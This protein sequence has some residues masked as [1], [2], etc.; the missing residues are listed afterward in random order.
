MS[1]KPSR[2]PW[3]PVIPDLATTGAIK[4][5][6]AGNASSGQQQSALRWIIDVLC[7]TYGMS[8]QPDSDR[9]TI[10]A[11]GKRFVGNQIIKEL[12]ITTPEKRGG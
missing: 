8:Y 9:D 4:A 10:F 1:K 12:K 7:D 6:N 2:R 3:H 5:L 11:E